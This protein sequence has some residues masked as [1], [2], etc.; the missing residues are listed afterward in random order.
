MLGMTQASKLHNLRH[1][2]K[3][4]LAFVS[5]KSKRGKNIATRVPLHI[6]C[7]DVTG[8]TFGATLT[9]LLYQFSS[10]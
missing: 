7:A 1:P 9:A 8:P 6:L 5:I 4:L 3:P 10:E 2:S